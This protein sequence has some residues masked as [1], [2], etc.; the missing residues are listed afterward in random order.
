MHTK[1]SGINLQKCCTLIVVINCKQVN[2][3]ISLI[4]FD[5]M[6]N[7]GKFSKTVL[8]IL[9]IKCWKTTN[10]FMPI[11][12]CRTTSIKWIDVV[13]QPSGACFD[14]EQQCGTTPFYPNQ[15][16]CPHP[17]CQRH[18]KPSGC[19]AP[20]PSVYSGGRCPQAVQRHRAGISGLS[21][22]PV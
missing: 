2:F 8:K 16:E 14:R 1:R 3:G 10:A 15:S 18:R 11:T 5:H 19:V 20:S 9:H 7:I 13:R 6:S 21:R 12:G 17:G 22:F 4:L